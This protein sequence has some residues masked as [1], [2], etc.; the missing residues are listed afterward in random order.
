ML[1][2]NAKN[3][4]QTELAENISDEAVSF[5]VKDAS[6]LPDAPFRAFIFRQDAQ[7]E[8]TAFEVVEV[9]SAASNTLSN[10]ER[11]LEGTTAL[12]WSSGDKFANV[13]TAEMYTGL[14][15]AI[16]S[17]LSDYATLKAII[18]YT[19]NDIYGIEVDIPSNATTRL[20]G[21]VGKVA[22]ADF[23]NI[24]A[25]KRRRCIVA[26]DRT[27][28][29]YHGDAG[30]TETGKT[31]VQIVKNETTYPVGTHVQ[32]MVEQPKFYYKRV[33]LQIEPIAN[34]VG[35]HLRKWRDYICD[36]PIYDF[37]AHPCFI[38]DG[39]EYNYIYYPAYEGCIYDVSASKYLTADEQV[40]DF[41]VDKLSS[42]A[43]VKPASG[44]TQSLTLPNTRKLAN[45][46]GEGWQQ[47]DVLAHYAEAMLMSIEY[48]TFDFQ[49]AIGRG[50][51]DKETGT[52]NESVNTGATAN[53]GNSSGMATGTNGLVSVSYRGRE[54][55]WG[56]IW[57][58]NDGLN[59]EAKSIHEA[60]W[61]DS[62]FASDIKTSPYKNCGFTLAKSNGYISAIGYSQ[63]CDFMYIPS[64]T[65]GAENRPL[66]DYFYQ[67]YTHDGFLVALLGGFWGNRSYAGAFYLN[68]FNGS[69]YRNRYIGGGL[70]C[71][72]KK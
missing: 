39:R 6:V 52:G 48:A 64:E 10:V 31:T 41:D 11:G 44:L 46:R 42:I 12:P 9:G 69:G 24:N 16:K 34:G 29:A 56:N 18:G 40:A 45:N 35:S 72:P 33:P 14:A 15:A 25:F 27:V 71:L 5:V 13:M 28:L 7:G 8:I 66:N 37:K 65:L 67:N 21:A 30:Y 22:G 51:V 43:G 54:N 62:G 36:Y 53:L 59:I 2:L 49:T 19:D 63:E 57:I 60:Y 70:L 32:V 17:H 4:A 47:M 68:V 20:A 58:W 23:D 50:V 38:R 1:D 26:D 3:L 55:P 61:A